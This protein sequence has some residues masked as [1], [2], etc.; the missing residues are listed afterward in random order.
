M[1]IQKELID[2]IAK[3]TVRSLIEN[4]FIIWDDR[5]EKLEAIIH[6]II[7]ED[8]MVEDRLNE[9][10]KMLLESRTKDYERD[11]MDYGR[12]FQ[13]VKSKLVRERGLIL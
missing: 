1:R 13:M 7:T 8:L 6:E 2:R 10:V 9:E 5:P 4:N 3:K 11:M 12:V